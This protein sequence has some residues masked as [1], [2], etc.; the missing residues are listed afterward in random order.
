LAEAITK[1]RISS[2]ASTCSQSRLRSAWN[3]GEIEFAGGLL[4]QAIAISPRVSSCMVSPCSKPS[5]GRG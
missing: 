5:S 4:S 3:W 1:A 2:E